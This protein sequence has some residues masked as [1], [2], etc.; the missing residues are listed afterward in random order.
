[1]F[2]L[3]CFTR[4]R[5]QQLQLGVCIKSNIKETFTN[6]VPLE[7]PQETSRMLDLFRYLQRTQ[8]YIMSTHVLL[9]VFGES[10]RQGKFRCPECQA[11]IDLPEGHRF[12]ALPTSFF[13]NSLLS[14]LAV[15]Q[16]R[17]GSSITCGN[18]NKRSSDANY[19]FDCAR[20]MCPDCL[21]AH[22]VMRA[23]FEGHKGR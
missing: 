17:D 4:N 9:S 11:Q 8:N 10:H 19:C 7:K 22:E 5:K 6:G 13:H 16:S 12:D 3:I 14:L 21:S 18:C 20:F 15:R 2:M 1:M 23:A